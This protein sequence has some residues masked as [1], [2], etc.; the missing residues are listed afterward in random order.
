MA[1]KKPKEYEFSVLTSGKGI[2][3]KGVPVGSISV[4]T[5]LTDIDEIK[6][7]A[8]TKLNEQLSNNDRYH[9]DLDFKGI[10]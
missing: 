9:F 3:D 5:K 4:K 7:N 2:M 1:K 10:K 8:Y 6:E